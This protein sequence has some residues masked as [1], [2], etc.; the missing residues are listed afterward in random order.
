VQQAE[1]D[2]A[3]LRQ[4][5]QQLQDKMQ[6]AIAR[7]VGQAAATRIESAPAR[8]VP[9]S[10]ESY[11]PAA[12]SVAVAAPAVVVA[13]ST[14]RRPGGG[15]S[16]IA[17][18]S[19]Q[20]PIGI[21]Q[22]I[23]GFGNT[24]TTLSG[25]TQR[26]GSGS[27]IGQSLNV[28]N[29]SRSNSQDYKNNDPLGGIQGLGSSSSHVTSGRESP[30]MSASEYDFVG[31]MGGFSG[32]LSG[33]GLDNG[34]DMQQFGD[35]MHGPSGGLFGGLGGEGGLDSLADHNSGTSSSRISPAT[36]GGVSVPLAPSSRRRG[37]DIPT[38]SGGNGG[39]SAMSA[40]PGLPHLS[41]HKHNANPYTG[42][43]DNND[44]DDDD[45]D[46]APLRDYD[47][48]YDASMMSN[49]YAQDLAKEALADAE[50]TVRAL[51]SEMHARDRQTAADRL[52]IGALQLQLREVQTAK[53]AADAAT[54]AVMQEWRSLSHKL[55]AVQKQNAEKDT[56]LTAR[57]GAHR[58]VEL[59]SKKLQ[60]ETSNLTAELTA[61]RKKVAQME[62][63]LEQA[64]KKITGLT[65]DN[66]RLDSKL[67]EEEKA[68]QVDTKA[69]KKKDDEIHKLKQAVAEEK[70]KCNVTDNRLLAA[71]DSF[72][73][74]T[75]A[76][77]AQANALN[78]ACDEL[79]TVKAESQRLTKEN[80]TLNTKLTALQKIL[81]HNPHT[82]TA[83]SN[84]GSSS[85][86][87][88]MPA[89]APQ[90]A[91]PTGAPA[92]DGVRQIQAA[93]GFTRVL[94]SSAPAGSLAGHEYDEAA[95]AADRDNGVIKRQKGA[96]ENKDQATEKQEKSVAMKQTFSP[97]A[98]CDMEGCCLTGMYICGSCKA[99]GYCGIAHQKEHWR[100]HR[101]SCANIKRTKEKEMIGSKSGSYVDGY[102]VGQA[103]G[104]LLDGKNGLF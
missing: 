40:P 79:E 10:H 28:F 35:H 72:R 27:Q 56:E 71:T 37:P 54:E 85:S 7:A 51:Q 52:E 12:A 63:E 47:E 90:G 64:K 97:K 22:P 83:P 29:R 46:G 88:P 9:P 39:S 3:L 13:P 20:S 4:Q 58:D 86:A 73:D 59:E 94:T 93:N 68:R 91:N 104:A 42:H 77:S 67:K 62:P 45:D 69:F 61:L 32:L 70:S 87:S 78:E 81:N 60:Q 98:Q 95:E 18:N 30:S 82:P 80:K 57:R 84:G 23:S 48:S 102:A 101:K 24:F 99:V 33:L 44:D 55:T 41:Q 6:A 89:P 74:I 2:K 53:A 1:E 11:E 96:A 49:P 15:P 8:A 43:L 16:A 19:S 36:L 5:E 75:K 92:S 25:N 17:M 34:D 14:R 66:K 26:R 65:T 31:D 38:S 103:T 50:Q 100:F 76:A 21:Q